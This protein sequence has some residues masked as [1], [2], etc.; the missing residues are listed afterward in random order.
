VEHYE[1]HYHGLVDAFVLDEADRDAAVALRS[2]GLHI[3]ILDTVMR[4][5]HDRER[6]AAEILDLHLSA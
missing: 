2:G 4:N 3:D 6:L 5:D 1:T